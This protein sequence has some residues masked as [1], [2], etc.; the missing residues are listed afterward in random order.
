MRCPSVAMPLMPIGRSSGRT[1]YPGLA[2]AIVRQPFVRR[3]LRSFASGDTV[4]LS[5]TRELNIHRLDG[6]L[7]LAASCRLQYY[8]NEGCKSCRTT[9]NFY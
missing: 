7:W 2:P 5:I 8:A 3:S 9:F 6:T 1:V 4:P